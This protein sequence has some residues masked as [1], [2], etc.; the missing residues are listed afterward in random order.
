ML[1]SMPKF[2]AGG[3]IMKRYIANRPLY[4]I[5]PLFVLSIIFSYLLVLYKKSYTYVN[6]INIGFDIFILLFYL[7]SFCIEV[8]IDSK[9]INF[10]GLFLRKRVYI[11]DYIG[12]AQ[13]NF[14][15]QVKTKLG[16]FYILTTKNGRNILN[17]MFKNLNKGE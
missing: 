8:S 6:Y 4:L 17:D 11:E 7:R 9:G 5:F 10:K 2:L 15:T 14:L 3:E 16:N 12:I 13:S 1:L